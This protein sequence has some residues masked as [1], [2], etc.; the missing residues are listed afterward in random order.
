MPN[1]SILLRK[2]TKM[3]DGFASSHSY[4]T[5][6]NHFYYRMKAVDAFS[7]FDDALRREVPAACRHPNQTMRDYLTTIYPEYLSIAPTELVTQF[8]D[9]YEHARHKPEVF[10]ESHFIKYSE[11]LEE[12]VNCLEHGIKLKREA[13]REQMKKLPPVD[14]EVKLKSH[15]RGIGKTKTSIPYNHMTSDKHC[16]R[17]QTRYRTRASSSEQAGLLE[18]APSSQRSSVE[19]LVTA[20]DSSEESI[21][22]VQVN[23]NT[24]PDI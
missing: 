21:R 16:N 23:M 10:E 18:S 20:R 22:L 14:T 11:M 15:H 6:P 8:I 7:R 9:L 5:G 13:N 19:G 1:Q 4:N 17:T 2:K 24:M 12:L 3:R